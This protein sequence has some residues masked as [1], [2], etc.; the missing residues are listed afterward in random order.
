[1][2]Y[3]HDAEPPKIAETA[4]A[5]FGPAETF[6]ERLT[7]QRAMVLA[8]STLMRTTP[9]WSRM[10]CSAVA[11]SD[12]VVSVDGDAETGT[13]GWLVP[14][15]TVSLLVVE[16]CDDYH[17]VE[18]VA[19]ALAAMN[20]VTLTV[21]AK[22]AERLHSLVTALHRCIPQGFAALPAG[23]D[24]SYPEGAT[25]A[26]LTPDFL[27]RSW[28]PPQILTQPA[29]DKNERLELVSLYGNVRQ[30]DVQFY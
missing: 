16:D 14:Q 25:V 17:A 9:Q 23:Q 5:E 6:S 13:L 3:G 22:R 2:H 8:A 18:H 24:A 4:E 7:R 19:S 28:A 15:G 26:V 29:R 21:D 1:M 11:A 20:A 30:L 12:R 10:L 27:F